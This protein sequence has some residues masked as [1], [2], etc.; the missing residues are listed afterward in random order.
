M[1]KDETIKNIMR[2]QRDLGKA[3]IPLALDAWQKLAVPLAQ[4]KSLFVIAAKRQTNFSTLAQNLGVTRG[5]VTGIIDRLVEQGLVSRNPSPDD[6][7]TIYLQTTDKGRDLIMNLVESHAAHMV[8]I[9][10]Y[11]TLEELNCLS[12]GLAGFTRAVGRYQEENSSI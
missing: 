10:R 12:K 9:L 6:R 1:E 11:L 7:R 8:Q 2:L 5:N 4:L 3:V